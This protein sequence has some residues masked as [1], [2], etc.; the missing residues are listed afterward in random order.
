MT[1]AEKAGLPLEAATGRMAEAEILQRQ[2]D[3]H[4]ARETEADCRM[5]LRPLGA[6]LPLSFDEVDLPAAGVRPPR[7]EVPQ[8]GPDPIDL[9]SPAEQRVAVTVATGCTNKEAAAELFLSVKTIDFHLQSIYRKLWLRS[10]TER[11]VLMSTTR[12]ST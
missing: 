7:D 10:R 5:A 2:G 8:L 12:R 6:R 9:L 4:A 3:H 1:R 11:A